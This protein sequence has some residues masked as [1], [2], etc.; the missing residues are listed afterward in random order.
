MRVKNDLEQ[1][2]ESVAWFIEHANTKLGLEESDKKNT[3][4]QIASWAFSARVVQS[5][6]WTVNISVIVVSINILSNSSGHLEEC[7]YGLL[8]L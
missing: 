8:C 7:G 3:S 5:V 2:R 6:C 4:A 1:Y